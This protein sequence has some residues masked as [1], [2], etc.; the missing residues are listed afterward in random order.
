MPSGICFSRPASMPHRPSRGSCFPATGT[1]MSPARRRR[2]SRSPG[3][4]GRRIRSAR[5]S[6]AGM[7]GLSSRRSGSARRS[8]R[9]STRSGCSS[10]RMQLSSSWPCR[11]QWRVAHS[12]SGFQDSSRAPSSQPDRAC[13]SARVRWLLPVC[14]SSSVWVSR[15]WRMARSSSCGSRARAAGRRGD[16]AGERQFAHLD[17][18]ADELRMVDQVGRHAQARRIADAEV[19]LERRFERHRRGGRAM[20]GDMLGLP[21]AEVTQH[22]TGEH[23]RGEGAG[24]IRMPVPDLSQSAMPSLPLP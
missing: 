1:R 4:S 3:P 9:S 22:E 17:P 14:H 15:R 18:A 11:L 21:Q 20:A 13:M 19:A 16:D 23:F 5:S 10:S 2:R 6:A 12:S 8:S 7:S 24:E